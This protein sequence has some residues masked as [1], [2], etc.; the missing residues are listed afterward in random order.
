[1]SRV[2][3]VDLSPVTANNRKYYEDRSLINVSGGRIHLRTITKPFP[4]TY[5]SFENSLRVN[6]KIRTRRVRRRRVTLRLV[7]VSR[8][9]SR[10]LLARSWSIARPI[11]E[12]VTG[13]PVMGNRDFPGQDERYS[14]VA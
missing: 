2:V 1:M 6:T 11:N 13:R 5:G 9:P 12:N 4:N 10:R 14:V 7:N 3:S 8:G